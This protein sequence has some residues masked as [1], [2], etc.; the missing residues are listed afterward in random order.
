ALGIPCIQAPSEGEA[1]AGHMVKKGDAYAV[2]SQDSDALL[3]GA[4]I[5]VRNLAI[6]G[7]R[8]ATIIKHRSQPE[9]LSAVFTITAHGIE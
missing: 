6:T 1:Q 2:A 9:G 7:R 3:F 4:P 8:K 5:L